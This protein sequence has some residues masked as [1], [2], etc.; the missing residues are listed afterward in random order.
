MDSFIKACFDGWTATARFACVLL[1]ACGLAAPCYG[2]ATPNLGGR[3]GG[4]LLFKEDYVLNL[5]VQVQGQAGLPLKSMAVVTLYTAAGLPISTATTKSG[6]AF[7]AQL[8]EGNYYVEV[9][10][11][12]FWKTR[13]NAIVQANVSDSMVTVSLLPAVAGSTAPYYSHAPLLPPEVQKDLSKG[14][15][16]IKANSFSAAKKQLTPVLK[17]APKHPDVLYVMGILSE[18]MGDQA[19]AVSYWERTISVDPKNV[20]AAYALG[21]SYLK[22]Q[23]FAKAAEWGAKTLELDPNSWKGHSLLASAAFRQEH[24]PEAASHAELALELGKVQA[25]NMSVILAESLAAQGNRQ[26]AIQAL[27][28][29]LATKPSPAN[30]EVANNLLSQL[31]SDA[32]RFVIAGTEAAKKLTEAPEA[33]VSPMV[34]HWIP[35]DVDESVPPTEPGAACD[36]P[37]ILSKAGEQL[38]LLP[39]N[40]DR[41][42]ATETV[43][44]QTV[45][46]NGIASNSVSVSFAYVVSIHETRRG[47]L[48]V[49]EYRNGVEDESVF[50]EHFATR[51]L[52][53]QVFVFH[54]YY[55]DEFDMKCEGLARTGNGFAW[56]V[57]FNQKNNIPSRMQVHY[58]NGRRYPVPLKGRAWIDAQNFEVVHLQTD[59]REPVKAAGMFAQH[60]DINYGPVYFQKDKKDL[61]LPIRAEYYVQ[62]KGHRIHRRHD[63]HDYLL[64]AVEDKQTIGTPKQTA[65]PQ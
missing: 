48:N 49:E 50:P 57:R 46:E 56:Q 3:L 17:R 52:P 36:L 8:N 19:Q 54:P 16:S 25:A 10:A 33:S 21:A 44:H 45:R 28:I 41:F 1:T 53:S 31:N 37:E 61:W 39:D 18:K 6:K 9:E 23:S 13:E 34:E 20:L 7:F 65:K 26:Q 27:K 63:F 42:S 60:T 30:A 35:P 29:Y 55:R 2:Q 47:S 38:R 64:F 12:G 4:D 62:T 40:L 43:E 24:Y 22:T 59:L 32:D 58:L 5:G 11:P 14:V 51:G 15:G